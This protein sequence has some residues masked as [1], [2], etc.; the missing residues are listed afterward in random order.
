MLLL[1]LAQEKVNIED[2]RNAHVNMRLGSEAILRCSVQLSLAVEETTNG[3]RND[4]RRLVFSCSS[5][6]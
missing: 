6:G 3:N 2:R 4:T 1:F 5:A